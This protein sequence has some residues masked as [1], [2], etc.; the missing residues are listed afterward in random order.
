MKLDRSYRVQNGCWNCSQCFIRYD[1]DEPATYYCTD[2][3]PERPPCGSVS[4]GEYARP[5]DALNEE[6]FGEWE[7]RAASER[8][9]WWRWCE[10]RRVDREGICDNHKSLG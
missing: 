1:Y 4:M 6:S 8:E 2:G 5:S 10:G 7:K 9:A 3:A